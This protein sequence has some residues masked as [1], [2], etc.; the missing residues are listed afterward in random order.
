MEPTS[1]IYRL[2]ALHLLISQANFV[3]QRLDLQ[4]ASIADPNQIT[5]FSV[6]PP[7][8]EPNG[9][10]R[11]FDAGLRTDA[12]AFTMAV[13]ARTPS[14]GFARLHRTHDGSVVEDWRAQEETPTVAPGKSSN[15]AIHAL[16][17]DWLQKL[18]IDVQ[19]LEAH[20]P[21]QVQRLHLP[22]G[23][24]QASTDLFTVKW[25]PDGLR[26]GSWPDVEIALNERQQWL[27]RME[28]RN[29][30]FYQGTLPSIPHAIAVNCLP[31]APVLRLLREHNWTLKNLEATNVFSLL[32][33]PRIY[34]AQMRVRL[35]SECKQIFSILGWDQVRQLRAENLVD[36]YINPPA[37]GP[38]G[39]LEFRDGEIQ[40]D[41]AGKLRCFYFL[42][43][44]LTN[45]YAWQSSRDT[46]ISSNEAY[47][48]GISKLKALSVDV[49]RL[50]QKF[51]RD[52]HQGQSYRVLA[53]N[54]KRVN[55]ATPE[56]FLDWH[57]KSNRAERALRIVVYGDVRRVGR[58]E[59]G[60]NSYWP[61]ERNPAR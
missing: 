59:V 38:G 31:D 43:D 60:D 44:G 27:I 37:F 33:I 58:V 24:L 7:K 4:G 11:G 8:R 46:T 45:Y 23:N 22:M 19:Q 13:G 51:K 34:E 35:L 25:A 56:F 29:F 32:E 14:F 9:E 21:F 53:K 16:A 20:H 40:F 6:F 47:D 17:C 55:F 30:D 49:A 15:Q 48:I 12:I 5:E 1:I 50:D 52:F 61:S 2:L 3:A 28:V 26:K 54:G 41:E 18:G 42:P 39:R 57:D 36:F 10:I